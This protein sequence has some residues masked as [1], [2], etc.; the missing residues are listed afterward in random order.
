MIGKSAEKLLSKISL[1]YNIL[2]RRIQHKVEDFNDPLI[3]KI[4]GKEFGLQLDEGTGNSNDTPLICYV[5]FV[6]GNNIVE[7][8]FC[9]S[10]SAQ[11]LFEILNIFISKN[12][13]EWGKCVAICTDCVR[14]KSRYYEGLPALIQE[15]PLYS[16]RYSL[17]SKYPSL[18]LNKILEYVVDVV[19]F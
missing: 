11:D 2:G 19:N 17:A 3:V 4:T 15:K 10:I 1:L 13:L 9:K 16:L 18:T 12:N 7:D 8:L 6:G 5:Q 14:S